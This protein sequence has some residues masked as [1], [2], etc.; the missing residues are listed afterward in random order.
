MVRSQLLDA[1]C[2]EVFV[3]CGSTYFELVNDIA[4]EW[5][6]FGILQHGFGVFD[7]LLVH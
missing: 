3:E 7:F 4:D 2:G 6:V 5:V 1:I